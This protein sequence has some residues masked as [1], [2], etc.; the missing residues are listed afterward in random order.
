MAHVKRKIKKVEPQ[1]VYNQ[2]LI[3]I[4]L[5]DPVKKIL[6]ELK[7][8]GFRD[9]DVKW[10]DEKL[11]HYMELSMKTLNISE[12]LLMMNEDKKPALM[13]TYA[14]EYYTKYF[15]GLLTYFKT[16]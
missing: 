16:F 14:V 11:K 15:T 1:D 10:L 3:E 12:S 5:I 4:S 13:N 2:L 7:A 6:D 9:C 8:G